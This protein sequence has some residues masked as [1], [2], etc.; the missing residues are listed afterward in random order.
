MGCVEFA[1]RK[2]GLCPVTR[3]FSHWGNATNRQIF[4]Q[5]VFGD[6]G[7][8]PVLFPFVFEGLVHHFRPG[9]YPGTISTHPAPIC[10]VSLT[11][12]RNDPLH[13]RASLQTRS[14]LTHRARAPR[15]RRC[16]RTEVPSTF[17]WRTVDRKARQGD[18]RDEPLL[19][20]VSTLRAFDN[21]SRQKA[22]EKRDTEK[23]EDAVSELPRSDVDATR[24]ETEPAGDAREVE[25]AEQ[26]E[27][28]RAR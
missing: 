9:R 21:N 8:A 13:Q 18:A 25:P 15:R 12:V 19:V 23:D 5:S 17:R 14:S 1:P 10:P 7:D 4:R 28:D 20:P 26:R 24:V 11:Q 6:T 27:G 16:S 3:H 2:R 22:S